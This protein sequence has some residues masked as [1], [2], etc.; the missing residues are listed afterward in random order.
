MTNIQLIGNSIALL[1][2]SFVLIS[3]S[4]VPVT[5]DQSKE[6]NSSR[7]YPNTADQ[8][9]EIKSESRYP[10]IEIWQEL[11][12]SVPIR[13]TSLYFR[14]FDDGVVEFDYE[15][16]KKNESGKPRYTY[17]IERSPP[18]KISEEEFRRIKSL[19]DDLTKS[20]VKQEYKPVALTLDVITKL[21]ILLKEN[22]TTK[23]KII[24][25][26]A[27]LDVVNSKFEKKFPMSLINVFK[28][29]RLMRRNALD[30]DRHGW[31]KSGD[32]GLHVRSA[33]RP[34]DESKSD[35]KRNKPARSEL[36]V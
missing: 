11:D 1:L 6:I 27:D 4:N 3:C 10:I 22:D 30:K 7:H 25:N 28:E 14:M 15:L 32:R 16:R 19:L 34:S 5:A 13:G 21:T 12:G 35:Q 18:T 36:R 20:K 9:E 29:I 8:P 33:D 24:I 17:S 26:D 2:I 31:N 23:R